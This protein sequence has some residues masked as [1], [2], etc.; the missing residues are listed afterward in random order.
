MKQSREMEKL[1][2][3]LRSSQLVAGGF[4]GDDSRNVSEVI[5]ADRLAL[6]KAGVTAGEVAKQMR[7]ITDVAK[8][9]LGRRVMVGDKLQAWVEEAKGVLVCPWPHSGGFA[10]RITMVR[11]VETGESVTWSDLNIHLIEEHSFFEGKGS[12]LRLCPGKLIK[13]IL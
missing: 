11:D 5:E 1:E 2:S 7:K 10:K 13:L 4:L 3:M 9:E 6:E 8:K 12:A